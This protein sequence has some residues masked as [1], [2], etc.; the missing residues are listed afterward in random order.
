M[1][2]VMGADL[3]MTLDRLAAGG[4]AVGRDGTGRVVFVRGGLPGETVDVVLTAVKRDFARGVA[5]AVVEP[6]P[7]RVAPP[8]AVR[9]AGCGGCDWQHVAT[10][11]H[12][13]AKAELVREA[14]ARIGG[15]PGADVFAGASVPAEG[16]RTTVRVVGDAEGRPGFR[17]ERTHDI[18]GAR[19][20]LVAHPALSA[21]L[22]T[23]RVDPGVELTLRVSAATGAFSAAWDGHPEAVCE[24]PPGTGDVIH[25]DVASHR[26]RVSARSFFQSGPAAAELLVDAVRRAGGAELAKARRVVDAYAG[27]GLYAVA[28]VPEGAKV[29]AIES[30]RHA[31][32]DAQSNLAG[33]GGRVVRADV[34]RWRP[35]A[36]MRVDVVIADPARR[37]LG[38]AGVESLAA[39]GGRVIVLVSC[40]PVSLARD[41]ALLAAA[42]YHHDGTEVIDA[43][44]H[45]HHVEG[46]TRFVVGLQ[47][48]Q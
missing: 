23:V 8:C 20:C 45:T 9:R 29:V 15:L 16:Y 26:L 34:G 22:A 1:L 14:L 39:L 27:V 25:E 2:V 30:S 35:E 10:A 3:T 42:G 32:A 28:A 17:A 37:G 43:F 19:T 41:T 47:E 24:L 7:D 5:V 13:P 48:S 18:V 6:S 38:R 4:D 40:D 44:P 36:G 31:A 21:A 46:V 11:A 33:R 12:L